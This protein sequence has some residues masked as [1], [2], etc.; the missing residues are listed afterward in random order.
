MILLKK[1]INKNKLTLIYIASIFILGLLFTTV[2][3]IGL[4]YQFC[5]T[6]NSILNISIIFIYSLINSKRDKTSAIKSSVKII[7]TILIINLIIIHVFTFKT[8]L[9]YLLIIFI[10]IFGAVIGK[11]KQ[12][13]LS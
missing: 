6:L 8:I 3:Y 9:Y 12:K 11:N 10:T 5:I 4:S 2:E 13:K 1:S 7:L